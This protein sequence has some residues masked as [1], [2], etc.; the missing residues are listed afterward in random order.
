MDLDHYKVFSPSF[1]FYNP[2]TL[3]LVPK[4]QANWT[5]SQFFHTLL[6]MRWIYLDQLSFT[7][8]LLKSYSSFKNHLKT[9]SIKDTLIYPNRYFSSWSLQCLTLVL[10]IRIGKL[11]FIFLSAKHRTQG[12]ENGRCSIN[13]HSISL[14]QGQTYEAE[15][16]QEGSWEGVSLFYLQI[17]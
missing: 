12:L 11:T 9:T 14:I 5:M 13:T 6:S 10:L 8:H 1:W 2:V 7:F 16:P 3:S 4:L 17:H 15:M